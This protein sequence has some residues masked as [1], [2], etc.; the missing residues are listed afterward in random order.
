MKK[1]AAFKD[2]LIYVVFVAAVL[3]ALFILSSKKPPLMPADGIHRSLSADRECTPCHS[4][5]GDEPL[6]QKHPPKIVCVECHKHA[7]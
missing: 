4:P 2:I 1:R 5:G 3:V 7:K 6:G